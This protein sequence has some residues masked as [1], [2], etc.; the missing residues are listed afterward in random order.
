[1]N[2]VREEGEELDSDMP[3]FETLNTGDKVEFL[4]LFNPKTKKWKGPGVTRIA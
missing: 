2:D 1:M 3:I 4:P